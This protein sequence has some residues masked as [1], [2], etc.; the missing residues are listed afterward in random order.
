[1]FALFTSIT[2][3]EG[4]SGIRDKEINI[5]RGLIRNSR[6][7]IVISFGSPYVLRHF[8]EADVLIAAYDTGRQ[9]QSSVIKCLKGERDFKGSLPVTLLPS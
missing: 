3:W 9:A 7:S 1:M 2:A 5:I 8:M 4:S 6:R